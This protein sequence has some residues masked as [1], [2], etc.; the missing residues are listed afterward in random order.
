VWWRAAIALLITAAVVALLVAEVGG[1]ERSAAALAEARW[2]YAPIPV[3]IVTFVLLL[4]VLKWRVILRAMGYELPIKEG[5]YAFLA[6]APLAAITPSRAGDLLRAS[7]ISRR[8]PVVRGLGSVFADRLIDIQSL[9]LLAGAGA[10]ATERWLEA[11]V[12]GTGVFAAWGALALVLW[13]RE[14]VVRMWPF[15]RFRERFEELLDAFVSLREHPRLLALQLAYSLLVWVC[16]LA[17]VY[18]L[19]LLFRAELDVAEVVAL[20]PL[21]TLF[22]LIPLTLSGMGTR[23]AAFIFMLGAYGHGDLNEG[24]VLLATLAYALVSSWL[25]AVVGLPFALR[26]LSMSSS[27]TGAERSPSRPAD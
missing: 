10:V 18:S 8:V 11:I 9:A 5:L 15:S 26:W 17:I 23:D 20:W 1:I 2:A 22:G 25:W 6:S 14:R 12:I 16:I 21:A 3:G 13:Q 24:S 19:S 7:V 4:G 27:G